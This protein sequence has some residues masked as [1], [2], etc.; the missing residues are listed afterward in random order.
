MDH[1]PA[2]VHQQ[3]ARFLKVPRTRRSRST[4]SP[5][6][7]KRNP[8]SAPF[9]GSYAEHRI[10]P[11][12]EHR[13]QRQRPRRSGSGR[14]PRWARKTACSGE[15]FASMLTFHAF[16]RH[17]VERH[18][19]GVRTVSVRCARHGQGA[20]S[21]PA[22][23]QVLRGV[24]RGHLEGASRRPVMH[25][26]DWGARREV[27]LGFFAIERTAPRRDGNGRG[28]GAARRASCRLRKPAAGVFD[29]SVQ[30]SEPATS[31]RTRVGRRQLRRGD[32][33]DKL[34]WTVVPALP[35]ATTCQG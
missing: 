15:R 1:R 7:S 9:G 24:A 13:S 6:H 33:L 16:A 26:V 22:V 25:T 20:P 11:S 2:T 35:L 19:A 30:S 28:A 21:I 29:R 34:W 23:Q 8:Y 4:D 3:A 5:L 10:G 27:A 14:Q 31:S 32:N 12:D 18:G 17:E